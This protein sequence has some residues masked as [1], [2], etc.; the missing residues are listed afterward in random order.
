M[1]TEYPHSKT[2]QYEACIVVMLLRTQKA[3]RI[4]TDVVLDDQDRKNLVLPDVAGKH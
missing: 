4:Y 1:M 3:L 2:R